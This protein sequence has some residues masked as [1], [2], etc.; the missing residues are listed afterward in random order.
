MSEIVVYGVPGSPYVRSALLGL[1]EKRSAHRLAAMGA[2]AFA[3]RTP[4]H[5]G[6]HPFGRIPILQ[7]GDFWLYET[8]AILRYLDAALPGPALQPQDARAAARMNQIAGIVDWYLFPSISVGIAAERLMSQRFWGRA[9][10]EAN[11]ARALPQARACL[12]ELTRL[13]GASE[14]LAGPAV[15]IADLMVAPHLLFFQATPEGQ[16]LL[17]GTALEGWLTRMR[18]RPSVQNTETERLLAA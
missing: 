1:H 7:H 17:S 13:M 9:P 14:F 2:N 5:L 16:E 10:D 18:S 4:E 15:T 6:R 8:Q 3:L 11:I 12:A